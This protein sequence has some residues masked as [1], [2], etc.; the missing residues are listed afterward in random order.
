MPDGSDLSIIVINSIDLK[1]V[2]DLVSANKR[3]ELTQYLVNEIQR[4]ARAGAE[5]G[6][7]AANTP[8]MVLMKSAVGR[9]FKLINIVEATCE[10]VKTLGLKELGLLGARFTMPGRFY[11][12]VFSTEG[13]APAL[14]DERAQTYLHHIYLN[15]LVKGITR[16]ET[17]EQLLTIVDGLRESH[18]I[19]ALIPGGTE[20]SL[21]LREPS[22][23]DT[24]VLDTT[25]IQAKAIVAESFLP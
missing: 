19:Q 18:G 3:A 6:L 21:I 2:L 11:P 8:H 24:P 23:R 12:D 22:V 16:P 5:C 14:P 10:A 25:K 17:R 20:L 4:L 9:P 7:G 1:K 13:I 15:A